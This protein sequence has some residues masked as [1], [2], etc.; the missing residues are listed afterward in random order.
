MVTMFGAA[1]GPRAFANSGSQANTVTFTVSGGDVTAIADCLNSASD[2][3][4]GAQANVCQNT[5]YARG[6]V[7]ILHDV[8]V[9]AVQANSGT[10]GNPN[11][12]N[13]LSFTVDGG[14]VTSIAQCVNAASQANVGA[15]VNQ[16]INTAIAIGNTLVLINVH[17]DA[18][19]VNS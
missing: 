12:S 3:S 8:T 14:G 18:V 1:T 13:S 5:A 16:C 7:V 6:N 17:V 9:D 2:A 10:L 4:V 11:Q 15:Q 19:Q